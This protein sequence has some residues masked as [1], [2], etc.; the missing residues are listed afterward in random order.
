[1]TTLSARPLTRAEV[2]LICREYSRGATRD[3]LAAKYNIAVGVVTRLLK[4]R[5]HVIR[6]DARIVSPA[7]ERREKRQALARSKCGPSDNKRD[8]IIASYVNK[9]SWKDAA[10]EVG[11]TQ[12]TVRQ[13]VKDA[14]IIIDPR[15]AFIALAPKALR[16]IENKLDDGSATVAESLG[17]LKGIGGIIITYDDTDDRQRG[18]ITLNLSLFEPRTAQAI[19]EGLRAQIQGDDRPA[20]LDAALHEDDGRAVADQG[21][22]GTAAVQAL[23]AE[24]LPDRPAPSVE[25]RADAVHREVEDNVGDV[26]LCGGD[27]P[28][29]DDADSDAVADCGAGRTAVTQS[30]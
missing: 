29:N 5:G 11:V 28:R 12:K 20:L 8:A 7:E 25:E 22:G 24:A 17:I 4:N 16:N 18:G 9:R 30:S 27:T 21:G 3:S 1:M 26:V 10:V 23:P 14:G 2:I 19:V 15:A 6:E 13:V